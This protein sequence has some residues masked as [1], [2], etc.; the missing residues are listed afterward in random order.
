MDHGNLRNLKVIFDFLPVLCSKNFVFKHK[1]HFMI[2]EQ[3]EAL[4]LVVG[5]SVIDLD[6]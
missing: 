4:A 1:F 2:L 5:V 6:P 3:K